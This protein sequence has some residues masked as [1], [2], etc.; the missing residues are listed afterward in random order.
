MI[1][2][3]CNEINVFVLPNAQF[4]NRNLMLNINVQII[5]TKSST[6]FITLFHLIHIDLHCSTS[7]LIWAFGCLKQSI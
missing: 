6:V 7:K 1:N 2:V 3:E 4:Y 5:F